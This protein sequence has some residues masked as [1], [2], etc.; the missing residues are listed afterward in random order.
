MNAQKG[1]GSL[2]GLRGYL[3]LLVFGALLAATVALSGC[4]GQSAAV[5]TETPDPTQASATTLDPSV[6]SFTANAL[7]DPSLLTLE[8]Q[9]KGAE[10]IVVG[11]IVQIDT[12]KW[13]SADG[14]Q[15]TT[16]KE[17]DPMPVVYSTFYVKPTEVLKGEA[18]WGSPIAF[19]SL[20][21][22]SDQGAQS[23][24]EPHMRLKVG[25]GVVVFGEQALNRYGGGVYAPADAYWLYAGAYSVWSD[26]DGEFVQH[27]LVRLLEQD[28][29][30][31]E[32][33]RSKISEVVRSQE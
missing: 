30:A 3:S 9:T 27:G 7:V 5:S 15:P 26:D 4:G 13:N 29:I 19:R 20:G 25:Q 31:P 2:R 8:S 22:I 23:E 32:R 12:P 18:K 11:T 33:L 1:T 16:S 24:S 14:K 6:A 17:T 21:T 10:I 28:V